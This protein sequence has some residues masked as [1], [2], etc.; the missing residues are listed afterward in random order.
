MDT[1]S[2]T[3]VAANLHAF[4]NI[5][6]YITDYDTNFEVDVN[7]VQQLKK[8]GMVIIQTKNV[9]KQTGNSRKCAKKNIPIPMVAEIDI[10]YLDSLVVKLDLAL[11][12][13]NKEL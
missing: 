8:G 9:Q 2:N 1:K 12:P 13:S 7:Y 3:L 5:D 4:K 11:D 10:E 6:I